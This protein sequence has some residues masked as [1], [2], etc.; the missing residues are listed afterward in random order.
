MCVTRLLSRAGPWR[1]YGR[2]LAAFCCVALIS[3]AASATVEWGRVGEVTTLTSGQL[4]KNDGKYIICDST[5]PTISG[6]AVGIGT[7]TP[8]SLLQIYNGEVQVGSS[9]ASCAAANAGAIRF[10]GSVVYYCNGTSW[11]IDGSGA[12][13]GST[14]YVQFNGGSGAFAADSNFFWDNTNKRLGIGTAS[15]AVP[16]AVLANSSAYGFRLLSNT[17]PASY[18]LDIKQ[19]DGT[20]TLATNNSDLDLSSGRGRMF[21]TAGGEGWASA[22]TFNVASSMT[23]A[24]TPGYYTPFIYAPV[25]WAPTSGSGLFAGIQLL[26]TINQTGTASGNYTG[27]QVNVTETAFLG[28]DGR[29]FDVQKNG[30][31]AFVVKNTGNV[32]IGMTAPQ[33][34]LSVSGGVAIGT[35]YAGT[36][37]AGSNNLIVQGNVGIGTAAPATGM[38]ADIAGPIKVAGTGSEAC[39]AAQVGAI[40]YNP[41]GNYFELC[42]YP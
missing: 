5:T 35:T 40:R 30:A 15:P 39:T 6:G 13:A 23:Y 19:N 24:G 10:S 27:L 4:C 41:T 3:G 21:F 26:P 1:R 33:S 9:G 22:Y 25:T 42:S 37:A 34:T 18:W 20:T 17:T 7:T 8:Q 11:V 38:K 16:L 28:T 32:G 36:S 29:L 14:G 31:S 12:A 2:G